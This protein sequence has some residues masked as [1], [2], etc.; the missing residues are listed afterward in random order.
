M[1]T[2]VKPPLVLV[3]FDGWGIG[4]AGPGNAITSAKTPVMDG[5]I[6]DCPYTTLRA[7]GSDVGL[8]KDQE[9]NSE[10]GHMNIGAGRV[11]EQDAVRISRSINEGR[12]FKNAA[13]MAAI[14]HVLKYRSQLHL[15]GLLTGKQ[16]GHADTDHLLALL[17]IARQHRIRSI[18]LHLFT[19]GR[20]S[21]PHQGIHFL[22][23]L[24]KRL[25]PNERIGT[26]DGR[27]YAMD[28]KKEWK[29]IQRTYDALV[30]GIGRHAETAER[31]ILESYERGESDEFIEPTVIG[32][33][34]KNRIRSNDSI[35]FYNLRSDRARELTKAFVQKDFNRLNRGAFRR[36]HA[37]KNLVFVAMT[38]FGPDLRDI[39]TAFPS[40]DIYN[41]LP[42][43]LRR[44]KQLYI[45][46]SEKF[47]H[48]TFF[49]NG[50]YDRPVAG[51]DRVLVPSPDVPSYDAAPEMSAR[52]IADAVIADLAAK[53]HD[54]I[55][56]N[57]A[58]PDMVAHT[59]NLAAT[60]KAV[61]TADRCLGRIVQAVQRRKGTMVITADHGNAEGLFGADG[62]S[63]DT[64]HS[65][66]PVPFIIVT[67]RRSTVALRKDGRLA[68]VSP[69]ILDVLGIQKPVV[70]TGTS[71]IIH[72]HA[73]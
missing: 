19:D 65:T 17:A 7:S 23:A 49:L 5:L 64:E 25:K 11:V 36:I 8:P 37:P 27:L 46:E 38:D 14:H 18:V 53:R 6:K 59:G 13:F 54:I 34:T 32:S 26:I 47:A 48:V 68:D 43:A 69:T 62:K 16:S 30:R 24:E 61:E 39:Y 2:F 44:Y 28:R 67:P 42:M 52:K 70:M 10:A 22:R 60:I 71:L 73:A 4:P 33:A 29:R 56:L 35:I 58:N 72:R 12:F 20:D 66:N 40:V 31:A 63:V 51:E 3:I 15:M 1:K 55:V 21:P 50:G 41:S 57:F 45:A 9:G